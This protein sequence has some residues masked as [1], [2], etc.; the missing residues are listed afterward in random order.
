MK[1]SRLGKIKIDFQN[2]IELTLAEE[3][4][5]ATIPNLNINFQEYICVHEQESKACV[6]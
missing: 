3:H 4:I 5:N 2:M 6:E 1:V